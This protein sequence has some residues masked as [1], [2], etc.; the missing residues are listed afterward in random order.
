MV[1]PSSGNRVPGGD[2]LLRSGGWAIILL[3]LTVLA[4]LPL[5]QN[6]FVNW[7][8]PTYVTQNPLLALPV[9]EMLQQIA[10]TFPLGNYHPLT[11][12]LQAL[13]FS[14]FGVHPLGYHLVSLLTHGVNLLLC[15][16]LLRSLRF[17]LL[18]A[19]FATAIFA[20]HPLRVEA[21]AWISAQKD[22][23]ST[24]FVLLA[25]H[26]YLRYLRGAPPERRRYYALTLAAAV[27]ALLSKGTVLVLPLLLLLVDLFVN[28]SLKRQVWLEKLPFFALSFLFGVVALLARNSFQEILAEAPVTGSSLWLATYRLV[29]YTLHTLM[30]LPR[31]FPAYPPGPGAA[32]LWQFFSLL[33]IVLCLGAALWAWRRRWRREVLGFTFFA[34]ALVPALPLQ[35][36]G[37]AADRFT[38]LAAIGLTWSCAALI[39]RSRLGVGVP[40][41]RLLVA[42]LLAAIL[43]L[44][45]I[46]LRQSGTWRDSDRLISEYIALFQASPG[47][48]LYLALALETR[49]EGRRQAGDEESAQVDFNAARQAWPER[50]EAMI[51]GGEELLGRGD[52]DA[53]AA[54]FRRAARLDP[55]NAQIF[56]GLAIVQR[57]LGHWPEALAAAERAVRLAPADA[58]VFNSRGNIL[59]EMGLTADALRDF[60]RAIELAPSAEAPYLNRALALERL[61]RRDEAQ[62]DLDL[63]LRVYPQS[64]KAQEAL[65]QL[66]SY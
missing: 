61:G 33:G 23:W 4:F 60:S 54:T 9:P 39:D 65:R 25:L 7:D 1:Q 66:Q 35:N 44:A 43:C 20:V 46:T 59:L 12:L 22:L 36:L 45:L 50:V 2:C 47:R 14:L 17:S 63:L 37:Y 5:V 48:E 41:G 42:L 13:E 40:S 19:A 27:L 8:D 58:V 11:T 55:A 21:V 34:L 52:F 6:G 30:P 53:A 18:A 62:R 57:R 29:T 26:A 31:L 38:Y 51:R 56:A 15:Y 32:S 49:G 16:L 3:L 24:T 28:R 64:V 10:V